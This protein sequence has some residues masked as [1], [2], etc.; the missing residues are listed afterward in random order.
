MPRGL[1]YASRPEIEL[2]SSPLLIR[3]QEELLAQDLTGSARNGFNVTK[4]YENALSP[5]SYVAS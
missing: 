4:K 2:N 1:L 5:F 3:E